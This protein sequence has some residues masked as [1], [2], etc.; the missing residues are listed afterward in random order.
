MGY[1]IQYGKERTYKNVKDRSGKANKKLLYAL[2]V[3]FGVLIMSFAIWKH[4][5]T[6]NFFIPGD[7]QI[8]STAVKHLT[9]ALEDGAPIGDAVTAF[10]REIIDNAIEN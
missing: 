8:T 6:S 10:C 1:K 9:D 2:C 4:E 3:I 7:A 5:S